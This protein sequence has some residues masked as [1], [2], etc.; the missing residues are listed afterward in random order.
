MKE[1][2]GLDGKVAFVTGAGSGLGR[3]MAEGF[4]KAGAYVICADVFEDRATEAAQAIVSAGG[5]AVA[6]QIDVAN[7]A[8][9]ADAIAQI[10]QS[11]L[12]ILVNCAGV[13]AVPART[14]ETLLEDW[15]R[16]IDINLTGTFLVTRAA[17]PMMFEQGGSIINLAS[18]LGIGGYYP[19]FASAGV[20]YAASKSAIIGFTK[21]VAVEYAELNIRANT[22]APGWHGGTRLGEARRQQASSGDEERFYSA[23]HSRIPMKRR[24]QAE[25]ILG[26]ALYLASPASAYMTGQLLV[27][28]GGWTAT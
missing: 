22:I 5:E 8:S 20:D 1:L 24:G 17:L 16:V 10:K 11:H 15:R 26:L 23:I 28:D 13:S 6:R 14:H 4:A 2:F 25:E 19:G 9:V 3:V 7:E 12:H 27:Q 21:Q 18:I